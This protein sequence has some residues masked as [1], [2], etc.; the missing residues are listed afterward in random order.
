[1]NQ[2]WP[3]LLIVIALFL[4]INGASL[5]SEGMFMDG[6]IYSTI[7]RNLAEGQG[8]FWY[9]YFSS[10][11]LND[12]H[13]HPPLAMGLEAVFYK[14]FGDS[15]YVERFYSLFI[16]MSSLFLMAR[17]WIILVKEEYKHLYWLP[18]LLFSII[19]VVGWS[20]S[21]NMLENTMTL[22]VLAAFY[23][24]L[25]S[26]NSR[27][28]S[29]S[30]LL[31]FLGGVFLFLGFLSKGFVALYPLITIGVYGVFTNRIAFGKSIIQTF[32]VCL[33]LVFPLLLLYVFN[34]EAIDSL[35]LYF[36]KQVATSIKS[37][38]TVN[39]RFWIIWSFIQQLIPVILLSTF[40]IV[41]SV[42]KYK[43]KNQIN[44][45]VLAIF[46]V[47]L[48]G[49]VPIMISLK[50]RDFY[51]VSAYPIVI[52]G[53]SLFLMPYLKTVLKNLESK[54]LYFSWLKRVSLFLLFI[55][56]VISVSQFGRTGRD[57]AMLEDVKKVVTILP[58]NS[59]IGIPNELSSNWALRG[60]FAR[61]H[62]VSLLAKAP[63]REFNYFLS[64]NRAEFE[65]V[66]EIPELKLSKFHFYT[67]IE[68]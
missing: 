8:S 21:N 47:G 14:I 7:S 60:Y 13:E 1:M 17:I 49:V 5:F 29:K 45:N 67:L 24:F 65:G 55:S 40:I 51:I 44:E 32:I 50:Q 39:S 56:L 53:L 23:S 38:S 57:V 37:V 33:G 4:G 11:F 19:G 22:F 63:G 30:Y 46:V 59:V 36:D 42:K 20:V 43:E 10:T 58:K 64:E 18:L 16:Y 35:S 9:L 34:N 61:Y 66:K 52:I 31:L 15:I 41:F 48:S 3:Y 26:L 12:F 6:L 25:K 2:T 28:L 62:N 54:S 68:K 27:T